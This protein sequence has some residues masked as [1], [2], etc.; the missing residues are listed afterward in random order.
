MSKHEAR[1]DW[2]KLIRRLQVLPELTMRR[3]VLL[4][5]ILEHQPEDVLDFL[6]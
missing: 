3:E 6:M 4:E 2:G 1:I 5:Q